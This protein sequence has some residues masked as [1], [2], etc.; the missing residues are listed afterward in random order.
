ME[1]SN[2][3]DAKRHITALKTVSGKTEEAWNR[4]QEL[5]ERINIFSQFFLSYTMRY[6]VVSFFFS[7][8][9]LYSDYIIFVY[10]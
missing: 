7:Y 8:I 4:M 5:Q 9:I 3:A 10:L 2:V 1:S 6:S